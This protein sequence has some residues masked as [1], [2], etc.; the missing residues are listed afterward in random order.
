[1]FDPI[2][3]YSSVLQYPLSFEYVKKNVNYTSICNETVQHTMR[4]KKCLLIYLICNGY[5]FERI[6]LNNKGGFKET[7]TYTCLCSSYDNRYY[8][9]INNP[10]IFRPIGE[11]YYAQGL[12]DYSQNQTLVCLAHEKCVQHI[13]STAAQNIVIIAQRIISTHFWL[14]YTKEIPLDIIRLIMGISSKLL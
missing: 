14:Y 3:R 7:G 6:I 11:F 13:F 5:P 8:L 12:N 9:K 1:M 10:D 4:Y 2:I